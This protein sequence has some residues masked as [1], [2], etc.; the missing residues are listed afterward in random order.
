MLIT[1][2]S[3]A[4]KTRRNSK[5]YFDDIAK[6]NVDAIEVDIYKFGKT[7]YLSHMP[8]FP[9]LRLPLT[10]AFDFIKQHNFKINC[11]VKQIGIVKDVLYL[12]QKHDVLDKII[13]TGSVWPGDLKHLE[14]G[15]VYLN[16]SFFRLLSPRPRD[17]KTIAR[18]IKTLNCQRISGINFK[19]TY[20]SDEFL[21]E[22]KKHQVNVSTFVVN[23]EKE[24]DRL[25]QHEIVVNIT[26]DNASKLLEKA[27]RIITR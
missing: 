27:K 15:E 4:H 5:K 18:Y 7:L 24:M 22:C 16:K 14:H 17:V 11:D 23:S 1:A 25:L 10:F 6:Y 8:S 19:H 13:F 9:S 12:A 26:T 2:H 21:A 20:L 3:G